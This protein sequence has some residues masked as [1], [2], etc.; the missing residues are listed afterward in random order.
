[1]DI[2]EDH[3]HR[4]HRCQALEPRGRIE[5]NTLEKYFRAELDHGKS[6][7]SHMVINTLYEKAVSG[8]TTACIW[9]TNEDS[10]RLERLHKGHMPMSNLKNNQDLSR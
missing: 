7:A 3:Q 1:M 10:I 6:H 5:R 4:L 9:W 8:D 2:F